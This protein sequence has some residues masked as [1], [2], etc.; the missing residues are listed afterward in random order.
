MTTA[1]DVPS[2]TTSV[3]IAASGKGVHALMTEMTPCDRCKIRV[4]CDFLSEMCQLTPRQISR[5]RPDLISQD[6]MNR[7][8]RRP[9]FKERY[10]R[11]KAVFTDA[12]KEI[13]KV[14]SEYIRTGQNAER[15]N[16]MYRGF[17]RR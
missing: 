5:F 4:G 15:L 14:I 8:N 17:L 12:M 11:K 10:A 3:N 7:E 9:Y 6:R 16:E 2:V 1:L 13:D